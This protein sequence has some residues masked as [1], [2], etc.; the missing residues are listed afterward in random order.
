MENVILNLESKAKVELNSIIE[1]GDLDQLEVWRI[2]YLGRKGEISN[3]M[4]LSDKLTSLNVDRYKI[5]KGQNKPSNNAK[6]SVFVFKGD[7]YQWLSVQEFS[8]KDINFSICVLKKIQYK[9]KYNIEIY[10]YTVSIVYK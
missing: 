5:W 8:K 10:I 2:T 1:S 6:Q 4:S 9:K 7:V 3:L